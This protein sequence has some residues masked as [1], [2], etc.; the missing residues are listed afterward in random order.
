MAQVGLIDEVVWVIFQWWISVSFGLVVVAYF[1]KNH[2]TL[3]L[4]ILVISLYVV[5]TANA[6][7]A[8][9][10][11]VRTIANYLDDLRGLPGTE[12]AQGTSYFAG[13]YESGWNGLLYVISTIGVFAGAL[14]YLISN[15][16]QGRLHES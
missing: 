6:V 14:W 12:L 5:G 16:R 7:T 15:Y 11:R 10:L 3:R 4:V 1:A 2:I 13:V 9:I 8:I